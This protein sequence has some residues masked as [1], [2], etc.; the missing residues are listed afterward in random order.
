M[1]T[2]VNIEFTCL[3]SIK[4]IIQTHGFIGETTGDVFFYSS[5]D[6]LACYFAVGAS[7]QRSPFD[8]KKWTCTLNFRPIGLK[9][10]FLKQK[11]TEIMKSITKMVKHHGNMNRVAVKIDELYEKL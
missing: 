1:T 11:K 8:K 6:P 5:S 10:V 2:N 9:R 3:I 4:D 7:Q